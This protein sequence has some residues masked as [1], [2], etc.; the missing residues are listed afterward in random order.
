MNANPANQSDELQ[1]ETT[2][3]NGR[4]AKTL[5]LQ[6][7]IVRKGETITTLHLMKPRTGDLRGLLLGDVMNMQADATATLLT[8]ISVPTLMKHEVDEM[9]PADLV[10]CGVKVAVF[11]VPKAVM[12]S[13]AA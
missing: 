9:D 13:L 5:T 11:L 4:T 1:D 7:P 8:R 6:T 3:V 12:D 2:T 10:A